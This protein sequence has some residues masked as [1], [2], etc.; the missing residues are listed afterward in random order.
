MPDK[1]AVTVLTRNRG[2]NR[3]HDR[4]H[5]APLPAAGTTVLFDGVQ[6][7]EIVAQDGYCAELL[8]EYAGSVFPAELAADPGC[9]VRFQPPT[10]GGAWVSDLL[11]LVERW[12]AFAPTLHQHAPNRPLPSDPCPPRRND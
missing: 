8:I 7:V 2:R 5:L 4:L 12:L 1:P 10:A 6:V 3:P 11:A 9:I